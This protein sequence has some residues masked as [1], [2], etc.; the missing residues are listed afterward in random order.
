MTLQLLHFLIYEETVLIARAA[1]PKRLPKPPVAFTTVEDFLASMEQFSTSASSSA[2]K[3]TDTTSVN[4]TA[5]ATTAATE[6]TL[7]SLTSSAEERA[8]I[9]HI[10]KIELL[11]GTIVGVLKVHQLF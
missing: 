9:F 3:S 5:A 2:I 10:I 11:I 7:P 1:R 8:I 6:Q 4:T